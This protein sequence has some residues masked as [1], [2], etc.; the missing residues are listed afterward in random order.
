M[1]D[2]DEAPQKRQSL[3]HLLIEVGDDGILHAVVRQEFFRRAGM[4]RGEQPLH[5]SP[6]ACQK[7]AR[8]S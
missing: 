8:R 4:G 6:P 5:T 2:V 1:L 7:C 3:Q